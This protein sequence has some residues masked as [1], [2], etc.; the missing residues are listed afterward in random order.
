MF[1]TRSVAVARAV[2]VLG[3][4][5][6][7]LSAV[8]P[9]ASAQSIA[10][11]KAEMAALS[12]VLDNEARQGEI[13]ANEYDAAQA[14]FNQLSN[15]VRAL[16]ERI[17]VKKAHIAAT[18]ARMVVTVVRSFVDGASV[19]QVDALFNQSLTSSDARG[20]FANLV[21]GNL[22]GIRTQL[23]TEQHQLQTSVNQVAAQRAKEQVQAQHMQ[24]LLQQN[25]AAQAHSQQVLNNLKSQ[26]HAQIQAF[27]DYQ[28]NQ[29]AA[30]ARNRNVACQSEAVNAAS[31]VGGQ[32]AA[33]L[34]LKAIA[35]NTP[36]PPLPP[37]PIPSGGNGSTAQG[38]AAVRAAES[39]IG[40]PYVWGGETAGVGFDCSGLVEWAW[41]R[42]GVTIPRTTETQW[43]ALPHV[44]LSQIQPGDL[45]YYYNLDGDNQVDH[46]VMYV[47][48]GPYGTSTI[49]AAAHSGT[50]IS[51]APLFTFGLYGVAR[52]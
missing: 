15:N 39:Q 18:K 37:S 36:P 40:V 33:D 1:G 41:A 30:C 9:S 17:A 35:A 5:A 47:G 43:A 29:G 51:L 16:Q 44:P 50:N 14:T 3:V 27:I 8:A 45:I 48:S 6:L 25:I 7:S 26:L 32:A 20:L 11:T 4:V 28:V 52:P 49:I 12:T 23:L 38:L 10:Q 21:V 46:V 24:A 42:A 34:V 22:N 31:E 19:A 2:G 13:T